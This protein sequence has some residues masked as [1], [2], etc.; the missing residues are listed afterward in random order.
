[1]KREKEKF[2][3]TLQNQCLEKTIRQISILTQD[4]DVAK[5]FVLTAVTEIWLKKTN[6]ELKHEENLCGLL[7]I[8]ARNH[9]LTKKKK[10]SK[11]QTFDEK[12]SNTLFVEMPDEIDLFSK[13][14][15][16][17]KAIGEAFNNLGEKCKLLLKRFLID[18]VKLV[19]LVSELG[20]ASNDSI[21]T[22]AKQ[23]REQLKKKFYKAVTN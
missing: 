4:E 15:I 19:N 10:D 20:Y 5:E 7:Y 14:A 8:M 2:A 21:R 17:R 9:W 3:R 23:C 13:D 11:H 22:S 1:M 12:I 6:G 18:K 16:R